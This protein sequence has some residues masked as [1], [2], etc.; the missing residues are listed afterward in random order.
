MKKFI[1]SI[2]L[3]AHVCFLHAQQIELSVQTGHSSSITSLAFSPGDVWIASGGADNKIILWDFLTARQA[4]VFI[5]HTMT[6]TDVEFHPEGKFLIS[7]SLDSTIRVWDI[8]N[9]NCIAKQNF[10]YPLFSIDFDAEGDEVVVAGKE[11]LFLSFDDLIKSNDSQSVNRV[12]LPIR[13]KKSFTTVAYSNNKQYVAFGGRQEDLGYLVDLQ[14]KAIIRKFPAAFSDLFFDSNDSKLIYSTSQGQGA[15]VSLLEKGK[16]STSTDWML[17]SFNAVTADADHIYLA[18]D[19]GEITELERKNFAEKRIFRSVRSRLNTLRISTSG[20]FIASGGDNGRIVLWDLST[21]L[22]VKDFEGSVSPINDIV[23]SKDGK[24]ILI[25]YQ[26]GSLRKTNLFSNQSIVNS[27]RIESDVLSTRFKWSVAEIVSFEKDSAV[28]TMHKKRFALDEENSFDK[29]TEY[30]VVWIFKDNYLK[31]HAHKYLGERA[32]H[33][34]D[35]RKSG[36]TNPVSFLLNPGN[37]ECRSM[38]GKDKIRSDGNQI[39]AELES[40]EDLKISSQHTDILT[41]VALNEAY[42]FFATAGWDGLIRF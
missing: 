2:F 22:A 24:D 19:N 1:L 29:I 31:L 37:L 39:F 15:E 6:L 20:H 25:G 42:G 36:I 4:D 40:S 32:Q 10:A 33:Y 34:M 30:T 18:D 12:A 16:M 14:K 28:I 38:D 27:P 21:G 41:C 26:D 3:F 17:N 9:G 23:F 11:I 13:A 7:S 35:D 8:T 5:G